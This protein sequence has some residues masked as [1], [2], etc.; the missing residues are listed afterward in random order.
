MAIPQVEMLF[1]EMFADAG[2]VAH[3]ALDDVIGHALVLAAVGIL[4]LK[5]DHGAEA[6]AQL[7]DGMIARAKALTHPSL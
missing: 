5:R 7:R 1:N 3:H 4:E 2:L 6:V